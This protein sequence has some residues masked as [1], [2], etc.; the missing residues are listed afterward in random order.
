MES[1]AGSADEAHTDLAAPRDSSLPQSWLRAFTI[2][3]PRPRASVAVVVIKFGRSDVPS[4]TV[5]AIGNRRDGP[6]RRR[7]FLRE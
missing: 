3:S 2:A 6:S 4:S 1:G 5:T 7:A